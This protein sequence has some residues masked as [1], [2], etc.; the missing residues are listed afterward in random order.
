M[1]TVFALL[2][3][4]AAAICSVAAR[5]TAQT[6]FGENLAA[7]QARM[8]QLEDHLHKAKAI[9]D[10]KRLQYSYA[11]YAELGL[12]LDLGDLFA[13]DGV[14]HYAQ[15]DFRG[16]ENLRRFY[17]QE[18]GRGQLGLADGRIYPHI[19]IQPVVTVAPDGKTAKGRW[20]VIA[21]LGS[22]GASA[23]WAGVVYENRYVFE[24]G[25]WKISEL[26]YN[27]QYSG[28]YSPPAL[29]LSK[30]DLPYHFIAP[31]AGDPAAKSDSPAI[32][33]ASSGSAPLGELQQRW[34][35]LARSAQ[36]LQS[37]TEVLNL[38]HSYGYFFDQ[39]IWGDVANLFSSD[40]TLEL[41]LSGVYAGKDRIRRALSIINGERLDTDEVNDHLQLATVV[42]I[43]H[44][45]KTANARGVELS[46]LGAKGKGALW[47]EGIF[48]NEY[49]KQNEVWKIRSMHYYPRVI[50]DYEL[51]W[52][53]DARPAAG[54]NTSF[55][56]DRPSTEAYA[57]YPKM[58]YP[59]LHYA[60]PVTQMPV[61]YPPGVAAN[62]DARSSTVDSSKRPALPNPPGNAKEFTSRL[63]ELESQIQ[64][65]IVYDAAENLIN[66]YGYYVDDLND[67]GVQ[68]LFSSASNRNPEPRRT[69]A[70]H[71]T[72][73]PVIQL[74]A[75][76]R[77][78]AIRARI[79]TVGEKAG[80]LSS[81]IYQG[82]ATNRDGAWKLES[83]TLY[84]TWSSPFTS[85]APVVER[86][87]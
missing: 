75:D 14:A 5:T 19:M 80:L 35:E 48:E 70:V 43:A 68:A 16:P 33:T 11:H 46:V 22:Y 29:T 12:W 7:I 77:S 64:S 73:Q 38:Q 8:T 54:P 74:A 78:A 79:L 66:A 40:G 65:S 26:S 57:T 6:G 34:V 10:I 45:G 67:S 53:K 44:D 76:G 1:S 62:I 81:G 60:N 63:N 28:R 71:Q 32:A 50:T 47:E 21:M 2:V 87:R 17:L 13:S 20:H 23:S 9:R 56:P 41:G 18:L 61:Q 27:S 39:K 25:V 31:S 24:G 85:W 42:H 36:Q 72:V 51:G 84:P 52:A 37:E 83:L 30:W 82:R 4:T 59:P 69:S 55:P 3:F 49:I 58:Y 15:G 86:R